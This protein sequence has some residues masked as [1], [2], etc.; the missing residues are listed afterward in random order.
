[1]IMLISCVGF[2]YIPISEKPILLYQVDPKELA[3]IFNYRLCVQNVPSKQCLS[4]EEKTL[5][6][7]FISIY[8]EQTG[9]TITTE[10]LINIIDTGENSLFADI[11]IQKLGSSETN[12]LKKSGQIGKEFY[13]FIV[14]DTE[15]NNLVSLI[16]GIQNNTVYI[17]K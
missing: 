4:K 7:I 10:E 8:E 16:I 3:H 9:E 1:M 17:P 2:K 11:T 12:S 15:E 13:K 6:E 14:P 5:G